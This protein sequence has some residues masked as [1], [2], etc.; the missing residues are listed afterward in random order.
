M[1]KLLFPPQ[2][3]LIMLPYKCNLGIMFFV[4]LGGVPQ[5]IVTDH[6]LQNPKRMLLKRLYC[7][8]TLYGRISFFEGGGS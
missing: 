8:D 1:V 3:C 7:P 6:L 2:N 4:F 5:Q